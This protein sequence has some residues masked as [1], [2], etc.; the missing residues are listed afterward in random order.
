MFITHLLLKILPLDVGFLQ[1]QPKN[2]LM[3]F[4]TSFYEAKI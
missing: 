1:V 2:I 3:Y 4:T